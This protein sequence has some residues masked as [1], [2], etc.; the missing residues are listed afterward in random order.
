MLGDETANHVN[1]MQP[2]L[3]YS[4]CLFFIIKLSKC[5]PLETRLSW[6]STYINLQAS[7]DQ[8]SG[9]HRDLRR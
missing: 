3:S 7:L 6:F 8:D 2:M 1:F 9:R 5:Q 4:P